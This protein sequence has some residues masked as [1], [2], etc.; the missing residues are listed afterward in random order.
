V[1]G[2]VRIC[3][4]GNTPADDVLRGMRFTEEAMAP[5]IRTSAENG[6]AGEQL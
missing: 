1:R 5:I 6:S 4:Q 2:E 3:E